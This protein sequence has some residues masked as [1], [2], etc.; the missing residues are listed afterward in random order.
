MMSTKAEVLAD[1]NSCLN[2][3]GDD[4]PI[5][6]LRA[7]DPLAPEAIEKWALE[8]IKTKTNGRKTSILDLSDNQLKKIQDA[9]NVA[10]SAQVWYDQHV[11]VECL[12]C[13][14]SHPY[15]TGCP[16]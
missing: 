16:V 15:I 1:P 7:N 12:A 2:K 9:F 4:E 5:F 13:G 8:Y 14:R 10:R 11:S 6:V 3:A